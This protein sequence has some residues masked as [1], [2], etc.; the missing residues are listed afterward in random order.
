MKN[1]HKRGLGNIPTERAAYRPLME[2]D[3]QFLL[4]QNNS[5]YY[6]NPDADI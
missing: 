1:E 4:I 3:I 2:V 6:Y 5:S